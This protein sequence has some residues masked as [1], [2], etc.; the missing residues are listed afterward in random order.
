MTIRVS[1]ESARGCGFRKEGG[2]YLMG[3]DVWE[4]CDR[5]PIELHVCAACGHGI[6]PT[7]GWTWIEPGSMLGLE[8]VESAMIT[9]CGN[10]NC[11]TCPVGGAIPER[12]GL[13]WI[14]GEFYRTT[15]DFQREAQ[16]VGI[17]RRITAVPKDF[18]VGRSWVFLAHR[19]AIARRCVSCQG[20]GVHEL[21]PEDVTDE[22]EG[23]LLGS[24]RVVIDCDDCR[25]GMEFAPAV[26]SAF[27]PTGIEKIVPADCSEEEADKLRK[28]GIEPVIVKRAD[29]DVPLD[30]EDEPTC[31]KCGS[32]LST[33]EDPGDLP[34]CPHCDA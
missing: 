30:F 13:L 33:P 23:T 6:K 3:G 5:L 19:E 18:E 14:G 12:A 32:N 9:D 1:V 28:R 24:G 21:L 2:L 22:D 10:T 26:F 15:V 34:T 11:G 31:P 16:S 27:I 20:R 25:D 17:S 7:R 4:P 8:D 29:E